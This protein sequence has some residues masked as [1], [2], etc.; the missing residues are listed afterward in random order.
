[1]LERPVPTFTFLPYQFAP[2]SEQGISP[3]GPPYSVPGIVHVV[4][5]VV[6]NGFETSPADASQPNR[7][8]GTTPDGASKFE[9]QTYRWVFVS[10]PASPSCLPDQSGCVTCPP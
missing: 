4:E 5:L 1:V 9:V 8:P 7:T 2:P 6:S 3:V 10:V